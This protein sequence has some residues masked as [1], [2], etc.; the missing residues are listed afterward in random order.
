[1]AT[2]PANVDKKLYYKFLTDK[3]F[4]AIRTRFPHGIGRIAEIQQGHVKPHGSINDLSV[5]EEARK[6][7]WKMKIVNQPANSLDLN[8]LDLGFFRSI[9]SLPQKKVQESRLN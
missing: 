9:K 7:G 1:M 6:E 4:P 5:Q 3:V 8:M 2:V